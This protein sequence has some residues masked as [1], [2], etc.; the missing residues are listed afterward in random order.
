M[1]Q[2]TLIVSHLL[3]PKA[4]FS[5]SASAALFGSPSSSF[6]AEQPFGPPGGFPTGPSLCLSQR[7]ASSAGR[8]APQQQEVM[9][10]PDPEVSAMETQQETTS[11]GG[12]SRRGKQEGS[13][14]PQ[15]KHG[16]QINAH[17]SADLWYG[18][19][20]SFFFFSCSSLF[21]FILLFSALLAMKDHNHEP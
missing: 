1:A 20:F 19:Q 14:V 16:L 7:S 17:F 4:F 10:P 21:C 6:S 3:S 13:P 11:A 15:A 9:H 8:D 2:L 12:D 18:Y 5:S